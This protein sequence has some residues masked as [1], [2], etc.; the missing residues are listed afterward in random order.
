MPTFVEEFTTKAALEAWLA[1]ASS[2]ATVM[3]VATTSK[4]LGGALGFLGAMKTYT[5]TY[6]ARRRLAAPQEHDPAST[7]GLHAVLLILAFGL[8]GLI[9]LLV[10]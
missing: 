5:V 6:E 10:W 4:R 7:P 1:S 9:V 2:A 8:A 3:S